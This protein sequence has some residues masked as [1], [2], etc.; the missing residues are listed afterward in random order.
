MLLYEAVRLLTHRPTGSLERERADAGA[1]ILG[2][3][4]ILVLGV[5]SGVLH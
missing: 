3:A 2:L 4:V 5:V 1:L